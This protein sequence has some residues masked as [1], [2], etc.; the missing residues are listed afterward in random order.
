MFTIKVYRGL[1]VV[2]GAELA[3]KHRLYVAGWSMSGTLQRMIKYPQ[4]YHGLALGSL[5]GVPVTI[6]L[7]DSYHYMAFCRKALRRNGYASQ[8]F[9]ALNVRGMDAGGGI[10]GSDHFW[11]KNGVNPSW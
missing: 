8:C 7:H 6:V 5:N 3:L 9:K 11:R 4:T 10:D 2:K 1:D